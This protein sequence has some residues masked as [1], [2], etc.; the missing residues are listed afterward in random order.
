MSS[1]TLLKSRYLNFGANRLEKE[2]YR[3]TEGVKKIREKNGR[4]LK[5]LTLNVLL[6]TYLVIQSVIA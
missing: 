2:G 1:F 3:L 4:I 6:R 5:A